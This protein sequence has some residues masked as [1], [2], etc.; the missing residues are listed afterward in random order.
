MLSGHNITLDKDITSI[1]LASRSDYS[2]T[3][4]SLQLSY[5]TKHNSNGKELCEITFDKKEA[6]DNYDNLAPYSRF[7]HS[8]PGGTG[9]SSNCPEELPLLSLKYSI[10]PPFNKGEESCISLISDKN[11]KLVDI[12]ARF[13]I[14]SSAY[15]SLIALKKY[16]HLLE[17]ENERKIAIGYYEKIENDYK[18]FMAELLVLNKLDEYRGVHNVNVTHEMW[19]EM[20][21]KQKKLAT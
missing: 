15:N 13:R 10:T 2:L 4:H 1:C 3:V 17:N 16:A 8:S 6:K 7:V 5:S 12:Y 18:V 21:Q 9:S 19:V 20:G 11:N 14:D